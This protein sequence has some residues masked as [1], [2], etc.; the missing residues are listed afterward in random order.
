MTE[1]AISMQSSEK[2]T[3]RQQLEEAVA[4]VTAAGAPLRLRMPVTLY[5][6]D[7]NYETLRDTTFNFTL[8]SPTVEGTE[9]VIDAIRTML[10]TLTELGVQETLTRLAT[11]LDPV[12]P[13]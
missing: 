10:T 2:P 3:R 13:T 8:P 12:T 6:G 5:G 4:A 7:G 1:P 11:V 9:V